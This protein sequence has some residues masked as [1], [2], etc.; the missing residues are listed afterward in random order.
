MGFVERLRQEATA[1]LERQEQ[2]RDQRQAQEIVDAERKAAKKKVSDQRTLNA[3]RFREE[4][5]VYKVV[6][7][8][9]EFLAIPTIPISVPLGGEGELS[10]LIGRGGYNQ[11]MPGENYPVSL[12]DPDSILDTVSWDNTHCGTS[13]QGSVYYNNT[14]EKHIIVETCPDGTIVF[15]GCWF[16]STTIRASKWQNKAPKVR[17]QIFDKALEKAFNHP[18]ICKSSVAEPTII[19]N[20]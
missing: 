19:H 16:G 13:R 3:Q 12:K 7:K 10:T 14:S 9:G 20:G 15:H 2:L 11:F 4:S 1:D 5:G 6:K 17:E 8:L 18:I